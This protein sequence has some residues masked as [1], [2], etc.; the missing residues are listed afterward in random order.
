MARIAITG[1]I[2]EGKSTVAGYVRDLGFM[3]E[4]SDRVAREVFNSAEV[5]SSLAALLNLEPPVSPEDMRQ[6]LRGNDEI[7][8]TLNRLTHPRI[9]DVLSASPAQ[10][11]EVPLLIETCLQGVF[12]RVWVVTCGPEEQLRRL[13]ERLGDEESARSLIRTQLTS[14][15]KLAFADRVL[16]TN[17]PESTVKRFVSEAATTDLR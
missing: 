2:A 10:V 8:R 1:G 7:R 17:Q 13:I 16:R 6:A 4:S 5:Q 15:A 12:D 9:V 14:D 11:I 3:V